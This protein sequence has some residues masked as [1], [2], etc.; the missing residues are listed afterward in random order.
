MTYTFESWFHD[1]NRT[2]PAGQDLREHYH[3]VMQMANRVVQK[4][5]TG[6]AISRSLAASR[7]QTNA[8]RPMEIPDSPGIQATKNG[9]AQARKAATT[10]LHSTLGNSRPNLHTSMNTHRKLYKKPKLTHTASK[11]R[12]MSWLQGECK[13]RTTGKMQHDVD[14]FDMQP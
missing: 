8:Q 10:R 4:P 2:I 6:L 13:T 5:R 7:W 3:A 11:G 1:N 14:D 12:L 9:H